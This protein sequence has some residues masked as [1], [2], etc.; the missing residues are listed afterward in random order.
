MGE[1]YFTNDISRKVIKKLVKKEHIK[2]MSPG[3][4]LSDREKEI[5]RLICVE[6]TTKEIADKLCLSFRTVE[7]HRK[8]IYEKTSSKNSAGVVMYAVR[9]GLVE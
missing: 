3:S 6:Y 8:N 7:A 1:I 9:T 2:R 5:I 4:S